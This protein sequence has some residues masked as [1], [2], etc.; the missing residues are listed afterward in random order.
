MYRFLIVN[1]ATLGPIGKKLPA[2]GTMGSIV[3]ILLFALLV[4]YFQFS[5]YWIIAGFIPLFLSDLSNYFC[6]Y[7][8]RL[9]S[10]GCFSSLDMLE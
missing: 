2:P 9:T 10:L 5:F 4:G 6:Y 7:F 3:G 8:T 1:I